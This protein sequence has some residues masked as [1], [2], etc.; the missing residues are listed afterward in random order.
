MSHR[1]RHITEAK[2]HSCAF[3]QIFEIFLHTHLR[4]QVYFFA[5][6]RVNSSHQF[7]EPRPSS[8]HICAISHEL[9]KAIPT[10]RFPSVICCIISSCIWCSLLTLSQTVSWGEYLWVETLSLKYNKIY[11]QAMFHRCRG[12]FMGRASENIN[13]MDCDWS[14]GQNNKDRIFFRQIWWSS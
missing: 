7:F 14:Q 1:N 10:V 5:S 2:S 13:A 9:H 3:A 11:L 6:L 4:P 12:V 8:I